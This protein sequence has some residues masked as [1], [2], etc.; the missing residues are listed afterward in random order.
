MRRYV[1]GERG[2]AEER[3]GRGRREV[4]LARAGPGREQL[5]VRLDGRADALDERVAVLRVA[6]RELED[7]LEPPRPEV[8]EEQEPAA[9]GAGNAGRE[10]AGAR[11]ELVAELAEAL[12][13]RGR[14]RDALAAEDE[15]LLP[16]R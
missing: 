4:E 11:D 10:H 12:D 1:A 14:G 9:E 15:R 5:P 8:A 6:D 16:L 2:V 3:A 13:R 7:V